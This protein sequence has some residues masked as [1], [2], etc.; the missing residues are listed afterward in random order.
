MIDIYKARTSNIKMKPGALNFYVWRRERATSFNACVHGRAQW[1]ANA[2]S[3]ASQAVSDTRGDLTHDVDGNLQDGVLS[4][5]RATV[6]FEENRCTR[7]TPAFTATACKMSG[8]KISAHAHTRL[9]T[10]SFFSS[11]G[12]VTLIFIAVHFDANPFIC[13]C[14][15]RREKHSKSNNNNRF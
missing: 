10:E 14:E 11:S 15:D 7:L 4:Q 6:S 8:A 5:E 3:D 1:Y 2:S 13:Q 9:Q 12:P